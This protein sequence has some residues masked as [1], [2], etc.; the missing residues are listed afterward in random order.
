MLRAIVLDGFWD[1]LDC[2]VPAHSRAVMSCLFARFLVLCAGCFAACA[3]EVDS[4]SVLLNELSPS[5][6]HGVVAEG[7]TWH[8]ALLVADS[9]G[10][11][12]AGEVLVNLFV[13][14]TQGVV[15]MVVSP[16]FGHD[17]VAGDAGLVTLLATAV[18]LRTLV[19]D[20]R[21]WRLMK[22]RRPHKDFLARLLLT[23]VALFS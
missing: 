1:T 4:L 7:A 12:A 19:L 23:T 9:C 11:T 2:R 6:L 18:V 15:A 22:L 5:L 10:G 13:Y 20:L 3:M 21:A 14:I 8:D 16:S 17:G